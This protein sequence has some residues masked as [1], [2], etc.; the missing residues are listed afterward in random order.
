MSTGGMYSR[1][2][3]AMLKADNSSSP[4][5]CSSALQHVHTQ[6]VNGKNSRKEH[7]TRW[8]AHQIMTQQLEESVQAH[9]CRLGS[10][11]FNTHLALAMCMA[12]CSSK[13]WSYLYMAS[14]LANTAEVSFHSFSG[15]SVCKACHASSL[16]A[17]RCVCLSTRS[18]VQV[19]RPSVLF[20][21]C[22]RCSP[23]PSGA[24][25]VTLEDLLLAS[26]AT[27]RLLP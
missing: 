20:A 13:G 5:C 16:D 2:L 24:V 14:R 18:L 17:G 27:V 3:L 26:S 9:K 11:N 22:S 6:S 21:R 25:S 15:R 4:V 7:H 19:V 12:F 8:F 23:L 10:G 1:A